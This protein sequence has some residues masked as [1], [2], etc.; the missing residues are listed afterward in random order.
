MD[1]S[2]LGRGLRAIGPDINS[3]LSNYD[4]KVLEQL[5]LARKLKQAQLEDA[6][7]QAAQRQQAA[8]DQATK[9]KQEADS[10]AKIG[11]YIASLTTP[12]PNPYAGIGKDN[13]GA[14]IDMLAPDLGKSIIAAPAGIPQQEFTDATDIGAMS[15]EP[16]NIGNAT[17]PATASDFLGYAA[18][19]DI[20]NTG[21]A[22]DYMTNLQELE[23]AG[24]RGQDF[25][26]NLEFKQ[27][28]L[29]EQRLRDQQLKG[30]ARSEKHQQDETDKILNA[31]PGDNEYRDAEDLAF[32]RM[33]FTQMKNMYSFKESYKRQ[34]LYDKAR[35]INPEFNPAQFEADYSSFKNNTQRTQMANLNKAENL[36]D[37]YQASSDAVKRNDIVALNKIASTYKLGT[38]DVP[39]NTLQ[40]FQI[41][42]S[43]DLG[44]ALT[45]SGAMSDA[46]LKLAGDLTDIL[47]VSNNVAATKINTLRE[48]IEANKKAI[49]SNWGVYGQTADKEASAAGNVGST[50]SGTVGGFKLISVK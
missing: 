37:A 6:Q 29:E 45:G 49:R 9:L 24:Q 3:A 41:A 32:G 31:K 19:N 46:K 11:D 16:E 39:I 21:P 13:G 33:T 47:N 42:M 48:I 38:G 26:S 15:K 35:D 4:P 34:A 50:G 10:K 2:A 23:S 17:R 28:Q 30:Q 8:T 40:Q 7:A 36:L 22:K 1:F 27:A 44:R 12:I 20:L 14:K 5:D 25:K 43:D 18:K